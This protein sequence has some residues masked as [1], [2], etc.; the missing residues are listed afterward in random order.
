[1]AQR[2][3]E[4]VVAVGVPIPQCQV[5]SHDVPY[6]SLQRMPIATEGVWRP[7]CLT[8]LMAVPE[9]KGTMLPV[10]CERRLRWLGE[11]GANRM[12]PSQTYGKSPSP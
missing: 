3:L 4:D 9:G 7:V 5:N 1:M 11:T 2:V 6:V 10:G 8:A 12:V